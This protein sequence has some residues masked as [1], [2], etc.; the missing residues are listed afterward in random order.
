[1]MLT[2]VL[3]AIEEK[4]PAGDW[5][6]DNAGLHI[7]DNNKE[8]CS[9]TKTIKFV[10]KLGQQ[11]AQSPKTNVLDLGLFWGHQLCLQKDSGSK[12]QRAGCGGAGGV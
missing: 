7:D 1:M 6:Q 12:L 10:I 8:F 11:P 2:K 5:G 9:S 4:W 3:P